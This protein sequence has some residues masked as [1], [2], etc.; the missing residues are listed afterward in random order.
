MKHPA[1]LMLGIGGALSVVGSVL[2]SVSL[3]NLPDDDQRLPA[4][5]RF[6]AA[7]RR[8]PWMRG[9]AMACLAASLLFF[10]GFVVTV[11]S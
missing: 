6:V 8:H 5:A 10:I 4:R 7:N 9:T 2:N 11:L 3:L 1:E